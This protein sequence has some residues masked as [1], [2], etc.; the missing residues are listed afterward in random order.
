MVYLRHITHYN[1]SSIVRGTST[2]ENAD[3]C[4]NFD[5]LEKHDATL[6]KNINDTVGENDI[7]ISLGDWNFGDY[8]SGASITNT[9]KFRE[10]LNVKRVIHCLGN[11]D[12]HIRQN[13]DNSKELFSWVGDYLELEIIEDSKEQGV[14]PYRQKIVCSHYPITSWNHVSRGS[15]MLFGHQH[16]NG[17][18]IKGKSMDVGIDCHPAFRPFSYL[19]I[20]ELLKDK[21]I[22]APDHHINIE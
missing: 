6:V 13:K 2:W 10:Q 18:Q 19:E 3:N 17:G 21:S 11:H 16:G 9:R 7:L 12:A 1:H 14:K 5:T 20:K 4:R 15:F 22:Y 8:K